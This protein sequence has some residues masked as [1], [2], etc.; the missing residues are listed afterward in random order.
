MSIAIGT[1]INAAKGQLR[2]AEI[3]VKNIASLKFNLNQAPYDSIVKYMDV[4]DGRN[5]VPDR[6][7]PLLKIKSTRV[8]LATLEPICRTTPEKK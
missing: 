7:M 3:A 2:M 6:N 1:P 8:S 4:V 5:A